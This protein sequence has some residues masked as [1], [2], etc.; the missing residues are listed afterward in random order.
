MTPLNRIEFV[1]TPNGARAVRRSW[2]TPRFADALGADRKIEI[3]AHQQAAQAGLAPT[4]YRVDPQWHWAELA[5]VSGGLLEE[6]W[7]DRPQ[8][9]RQMQRSLALLQTLDA[10]ALPLIDPLERAAELLARL[11]AVS[12][13][14]AADLWQRCEMLRRN[15]PVVT[16]QPRRPCLVHG[17]LNRANVLIGVDDELQ[18]IDWEYAHRG[19][20]LEDWAG[21]L[22]SEPGLRQAW[23]QRGEITAELAWWIACR[24]VLDGAWLALRAHL[25]REAL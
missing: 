20:P 9:V 10:G 17:D 5:F 21:L 24:E 18:F 22:V 23:Q 8:R 2:V 11:A 12:P 14:G 6:D 1:T 13:S 3:A 15:R 19:D 7:C 16:G 25:P 4:I